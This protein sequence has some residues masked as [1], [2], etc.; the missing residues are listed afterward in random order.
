M[1]AP[2]QSVVE[3]QYWL[4]KLGWTVDDTSYSIAD[5]KDR[6][7]ASDMIDTL[8]SNIRKE[9][10]KPLSTSI[11]TVGG[12]GVTATDGGDGGI[13]LSTVPVSKLTKYTYGESTYFKIANAIQLAINPPQPSA[14]VASAGVTQRAAREDHIH[15]LPPA[16][17]S[18]V[19]IASGSQVTMG[20]P[21]GTATPGATPR[22]LF[23]FIYL[24]QPS[25]GLM[26]FSKVSFKV[27]N[28]AAAGGVGRIAMWKTTANGDWDFTQKVFESGPIATTSTG[29]KDYV[30]SLTNLSEGIY[31]CGY[32][33]QVAQAG[34]SGIDTGLFGQGGNPGQMTDFWYQD[35][36]SG[37]FPSTPAPNP[38]GDGTVAFYFTYA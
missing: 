4:D 15:I 19:R 33:G 36:I 31:V 18:T 9:V 27:D 1:P 23:C 7:Y 14:S 28:A 32:V 3:R 20:K 11:Q 29:M 38:G 17:P 2:D 12:G 22:A 16:K 35:G 5:L 25:R 34:V 24:T 30:V 21:Q 8:D 13:T 37:A 6:Y 10:G 26:S